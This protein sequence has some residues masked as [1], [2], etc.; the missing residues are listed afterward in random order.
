MNIKKKYDIALKNKNDEE[1][2]KIE[3]ELIGIYI[4]GIF[5]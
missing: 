5:F 3:N 2:H 1:A 4:H